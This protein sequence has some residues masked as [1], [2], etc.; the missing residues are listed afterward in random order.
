MSATVVLILA[1]IVLFALLAVRVPIAI[2]LISVSVVGIVLVR[3]LRPAMQIF[4]QEPFS[5]VSSWTLSAIPLFIFMGTLVHSTGLSA[6][7]FR[8][9][10]LWLSRL[11][12]GLAVAANFACA[13]FSAAS[14]SSVS[15]AAAMGRIAIPEMLRHGYQPGLATAVVASAGTLGSLIPPSIIFILYGIF[16]GVS[17]NKLFLAGILPGLLTAGLY[18]VMIM[19]R[20]AISPNLAPVVV[21]DVTWRERFTSLIGVLPLIVIIAV[22]LG[23]IYGGLFTATEAGAFGALSVM[24]TAFLQRRL[25]FAS[26]KE[27]LFEAVISTTKIFFVA[28][29][30][31]LLTKFLAITGSGV[32]LAQLAV[33]MQDNTLMMLVM[34]VV[35]YLILG[36]FLD[37]IGILLITLPVFLPV[38]KAIDFDLILYGVLVVKFIEIGLLTPPV[39]LNVFVIKSVVSNDIPV[40]AIFKGVAWFLLCETIV[41]LLLFSFPQISLFLPTTFSG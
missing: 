28:I 31:V 36:M 20:C 39:G 21:D 32:Q 22:V 17:I 34:M 19:I 16:A 23:G 30:A 27:A 15:T 29:G 1:I 35:I 13:G 26:L 6:A 25:T 40:G 38:L 8:A 3:G 33:A 10:R 5:F 14:G 11:P 41:V 37:P 18:V 2:A 24:I 9:S 7:L 4:A 12:G